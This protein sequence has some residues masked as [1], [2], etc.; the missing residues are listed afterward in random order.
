V[1]DGRFIAIVSPY[2]PRFARLAG[3]QL[4]NHQEDSEMEKKEAR[5]DRELRA[6]LEE[7]QSLRH[8][9]EILKN[10]PVIGDAV[11]ASLER[12]RESAG[13][14]NSHAAAAPPAGELSPEYAATA[15]RGRP[16]LVSRARTMTRTTRAKAA[17][18][19]KEASRGKAGAKIGSGTATRAIRGKAGAKTAPGTATRT[20][21]KASRGKAAA[22]TASRAAPRAATKAIRGKA[23]PV[24]A[25]KATRGK[26]AAPAR[27]ARKSA[28]KQP[29][30]SRK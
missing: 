20:A 10:D 27:G 15:G 23:A 5:R 24:A 22:K 2:T 6:L 1:G 14:R 19:A 21:T 30:T 25:L 29:A 8:D 26:A 17:T 28:A 4:L 7:V 3:E 16:K 13:Q 9:I 11:S 18:K 12:V